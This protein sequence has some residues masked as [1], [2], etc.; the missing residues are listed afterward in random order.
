[1]KP[2]WLRLG[3]WRIVSPLVV[4]TGATALAQSPAR[5]SA[6]E[7]VSIKRNTSGAMPRGNGLPPGR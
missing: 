1:M 3:P 5:S 4:L 7:A 6:F 2:S